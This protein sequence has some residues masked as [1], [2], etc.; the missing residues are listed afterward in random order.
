MNKWQNVCL[1]QGDAAKLALDRQVD[2][3]VSTL[4]VAVIPDYREALRRMVAHVR[5]DGRVVIAECKLSERIPAI[6]A[7]AKR[8]NASNSLIVITPIPH[9]KPI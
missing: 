5:P 1:I 7:I 6:N 4:A 2:A 8:S 3:A 9:G